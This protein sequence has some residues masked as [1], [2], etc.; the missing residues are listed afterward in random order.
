MSSWVPVWERPQV[1][2]VC[3]RALTDDTCGVWQDALYC[4]GHWVTAVRASGVVYAFLGRG[5][6]LPT[7]D[8]Q[9]NWARE[10]RA[11]AAGD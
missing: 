5:R 6:P 9:I 1:C 4:P 11:G 7:T 2:G 10:R 3:L 8:H